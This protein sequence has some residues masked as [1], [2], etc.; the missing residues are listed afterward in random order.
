MLKELV[1]DVLRE[2][3][4]EI[5]NIEDQVERLTAEIKSTAKNLFFQ[6]KIQDFRDFILNIPNENNAEIKSKVKASIHSVI[7]NTDEFIDVFK[8]KIE[9][10][11]EQ[12]QKEKSLDSLLEILGYAHLKDM[13]KMFKL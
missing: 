10:K 1:A 4:P 7:D 3:Q 11:L 5:D 8:L 12:L 9:F 2:I 6:G 13:L